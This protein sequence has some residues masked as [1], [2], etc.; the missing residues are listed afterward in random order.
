MAVAHLE[1]GFATY[2][3]VESVMLPCDTDNAGCIWG[4]IFNESDLLELIGEVVN[5]K[6]RWL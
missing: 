6:L 1:H 3:E 2:L 4:R 5:G